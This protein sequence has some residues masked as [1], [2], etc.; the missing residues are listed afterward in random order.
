MYNIITNDGF[1]W[2]FSSLREALDYSKWCLKERV[3][4][5]VC[6]SRLVKVI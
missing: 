6:G 3:A 2:S 5:I 1:Y 4:A